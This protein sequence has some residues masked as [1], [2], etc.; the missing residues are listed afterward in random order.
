MILE[1]ATK[2]AYGYYARELTRGSENPIVAA[3][4]FRGKIRITNKRSYRTFCFVCAHKKG[5]CTDIT[6]DL[7]RIV[8][9]GNTNALGCKHSNE[10]NALKSAAQ[11]GKIV[12]KETKALMS[13]A[14]KGD[15]NSMYGKT[16]D[17]N[18]NWL[19]GI[20]FGKYCHRFN[21]E[22]KRK[23]RERFGNKCFLSNKTSEENGRALDVHHVNYNK[24]CECDNSKCIC[25]PLCHSCHMKTNSNREYWEKKITNKL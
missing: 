5:C 6:R 8:H 17:K 23:I 13:A 25:V 1:E 14:N 24:D 10:A 16:G 15:K 4:E 7:L 22:Y 20:S 11:K 12:S 19:G 2:E 3:C 21:S 9:K 18:P